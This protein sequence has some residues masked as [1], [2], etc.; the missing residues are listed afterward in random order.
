MPKRILTY[1]H[2]KRYGLIGAVIGGL[3]FSYIPFWVNNYI[4]TVGA[5]DTW[6]VDVEKIVASDMETG[7][8]YQT[9]EIHREVH[10]EINGKPRQELYHVVGDEEVEIYSTPPSRY[11]AD[12]EPREAN[13]EPLDFDFWVNKGVSDDILAVIEQGQE[14]RWVWVIEFIRPNG[15]TETHRYPS[16]VWTAI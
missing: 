5:I 15:E 1:A 2:N 3:L 6:Y 10:R 14:Y 9:V 11:V 7:T 16:N 12:Y 13:V 8:T 4:V